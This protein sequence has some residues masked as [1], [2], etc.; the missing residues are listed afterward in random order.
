MQLTQQPQQRHSRIKNSL[1]E[2]ENY[3]STEDQRVEAWR[4]LKTLTEKGNKKRLDKEEEQQWK[5]SSDAFLSEVESFLKDSVLTSSAP[6]QRQL[7]T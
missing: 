5:T 6:A 3:K 4:S 1:N 2:K 7:I